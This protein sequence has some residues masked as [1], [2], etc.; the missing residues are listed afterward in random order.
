MIAVLMSVLAVPAMAVLS[1]PIA[2]DATSQAGEMRV[3]GGVT[4]ESDW[5]MYGGRFSYGVNDRISVFGGAGLADPD[6][7]DSEPYFQFGGKYVL[8]L[9][10]DFDLAIRGAL[11]MV[12]FSESYF[13][14]KWELDLMTITVGALGSKAID[15]HLTV[16]GFGGLSYQKLESKGSGGG[17]RHSYSDTETE[18]AIAGGAIY[19]MDAQLSFYGELA[20][21]DDLFISGGVRY[22]F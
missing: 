9:G 20:L 6:G 19:A 14:E 17:I 12:S 2:E 16:Y 8:D 13:G 5:M 21:I 10:L 11:G 22:T 4:L 3:S 7:W 15:Q 18:L 1:L